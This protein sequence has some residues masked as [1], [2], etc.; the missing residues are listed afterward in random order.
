MTGMAI[1]VVLLLILALYGWGRACALA[2]RMAPG[3]AFA[4]TTALGLA[5]VVF[6]G[7]LLNLFRLASAWALACLLAGGVILAVWS[8]RRRLPP[9]AA[10]S[11]QERRATVSVLLDHALPA[12]LMLA[13]LSFTVLTQF[14]PQAYNCHD[15]LQKYFA[16]PVRMLQTGTLFGS[17][18]SAA[19]SEA[20][21]GQAFLQA[22]LVAW[23]PLRYINGLDAVL[24]LF[25]CLSQAAA[26]T[27]GR[28]DL[29][30]VS[31]A[32]LLS[33]Y[34]INPQYVNVSSLYTGSAVIMALI[35]FSARPDEPGRGRPGPHPAAMGMLYAALIALKPTFALFVGL[36]VPAAAAAA[37]LS[38]DSWR[39]AGKRAGAVVLFAAVFLCPWVMLHS[40]H[41]VAGWQATDDPG[42]QIEEAA[43]DEIGLFSTDPLS[44]GASVLA[45]TGLMSAVAIGSVVAAWAGAR[46]ADGGTRRSA[47]A[48]AAA[49]GTGAVAYVILFY[50]GNELEGRCTSV[51]L[52]TPFCIGIAPVVFGYTAVH[53][54][55]SG[56]F[57]PPSRAM[58]LALLLACAPL[59]GFLPSLYSRMEQ[60]VRAGFVLPFIPPEDRGRYLEYNREALSGRARERIA[61]AQSAVPA[62][63]TVLAWID[64]PFHLDFRRNT[65]I[66]AD[67]A[68]L[69]A[70]WATMPAVEYVIWERGAYATRS[71]MSYLQQAEGPGARSR[72]VAIRTLLFMD[73]LTAGTN[74]GQR[75]Y[76]DG[77]IA[78]FRLGGE[79]A[80]PAGGEPNRL[81]TR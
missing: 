62:G 42:I 30:A 35:A 41:Y 50:L 18:L 31:A 52:F 47:Y 39:T 21:G 20:L 13:I 7:G 59:L 77:D 14:P 57:G 37:R 64:A 32:S 19:G 40:P 74:K 69:G 46:A 45:Y 6:L 23:L 27:R 55:S 22:M 12:G 72:E 66:D 76:Q 36:H 9:P 58:T 56:G 70:P 44:Y 78:V 49:G 68:G 11:R 53:M 73:R 54:A 29:L 1:G 43:E 4:Q 61:A 51:R 24:G 28:R 60:A 25:L 33:V 16:H 3:T 17:P 63:K 75:V 71:P 2:F 5:A 81:S 26:I 48:I 80:A 34:V 15:D 67:T 65:V 38:G 79:G 10:A 8:L